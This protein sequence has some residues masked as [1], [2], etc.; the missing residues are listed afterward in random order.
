[1]YIVFLAGGIASG[2]SSVARALED[3]GC[4]RIDLDALSR[5]VLE[6]GMP[7]THALADAFG[8]DSLDAGTGRLNRALL[9]EGAFASASSTE[10][11]EAIELPY[12][13]ELRLERL[14]ALAPQEG[15]AVVEVPL[16]DRVGDLLDAA[17]EVVYVH[18][19]RE[20]RRVRAIGRGMHGED[21]DARD[22]RQPSEDYLFSHADTILDNSGTPGELADA[23]LRWWKSRAQHVP[24]C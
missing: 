4:T 12:I 15:V 7:C 6:P 22:A 24:S 5:E 18:A 11:L 1:M 23:V 19:P 3:L 8:A 21:F 13:R 16:L 2:K 17:D 9:A 20:I 14:D 10:L